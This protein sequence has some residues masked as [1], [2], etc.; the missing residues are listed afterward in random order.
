MYVDSHC[1]LNFPELINNI[2]VILDRMKINQVKHALIAS[3]SIPGLTSILDLINNYDNLWGS[4][5]IHP[6]YENKKELS[7]DKLCSLT[8]HP[9]IIAIGETGLDYYRLKEPL[10]WQ[11]N[12]FYNHIQAAKQ[13]KLP[14]IIHTRAAIQD[15]IK[16]LQNE[17][18]SEIGGVM[19]CFT[20]NW[21]IAKIAMD[22]NF[23][24]S[25]S[26]IVTF[27]SAHTVHEVARKVP[28]THLL[29][30]T[31]SPFLTPVPHRG[32]LNDPSMVINVAKKIAEI[33]G[34][35]VHEVAE[36]SSR[37][38]FQ[39]FRKINLISNI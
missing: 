30:E 20:E 36:A 3:I 8:E 35:S 19:H 17:R 22:M 1:H 25:I 29:I 12:R 7:I 10:D 34:I 15:T 9:K 5:G 18:A 14:L 39:I 31:D 32:K 23:F 11:R 6:N 2:S 37:N 16:I 33:R 38:F 27:K 21:N 24:I 26:G 28:L 4:V 13:T